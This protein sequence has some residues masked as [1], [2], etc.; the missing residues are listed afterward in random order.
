MQLTTLEQGP[1]IV[2]CV[3]FL[4]Q[5]MEEDEQGVGF[6]VRHIVLV[7]LGEF[8][9]EGH[10]ALVG[11]ESRTIG[12]PG[13]P[14]GMSPLGHLAK[15]WRRRLEGGREDGILVRRIEHIGL[16]ETDMYCGKQEKQAQDL[17]HRELALEINSNRDDVNK[18]LLRKASDQ[19]VFKRN[20]RSCATVQAGKS[21]ESLS[22]MKHRQ[23]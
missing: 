3:T 22:R 1:F 19:K 4:A 8:Q 23:A 12:A 6:T 14:Y 11:L 7:G 18:N 15:R 16:S 20:W 10:A 13:L 9:E 5:S 2:P 21:G 17:P